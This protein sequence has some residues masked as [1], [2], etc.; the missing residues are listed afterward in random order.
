MSTP[1]QDRA[2]YEGVCVAL[3]VVASHDAET[4]WRDIV[5]S[6][7][8]YARLHAIS[9][10]CGNLAIDGFKRYKPEPR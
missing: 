8:G 7:G 5:R 10:R 1:Q 6:C 4:V 9:K 2:F 3:A